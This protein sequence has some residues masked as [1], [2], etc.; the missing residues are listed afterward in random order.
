MLRIPKHGTLAL[1]IHQA[2]ACRGSAD[3]GSPDTYRWSFRHAVIRA[4]S[5]A[6]LVVALVVVFLL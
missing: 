6:L 3:D 2:F 5:T 4:V 1:E